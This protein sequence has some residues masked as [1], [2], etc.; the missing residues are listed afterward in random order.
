LLPATAAEE[1]IVYFTTLIN[2]TIA[3]TAIAES[4]LTL[5]ATRNI[6][7][8]DQAMKKHIYLPLS[9]LILSFFYLQINGQAYKNSIEE[10]P[11]GSLTEANIDSGKLT[12]LSKEISKG[13]N[14]IHS[15]LI[16]RNNKLV[17]ETYYRGKD[18]ILTTPVGEKDHGRDSLHDCRS[19]TKSV[20]SCCIGVAIGQHK[21]KSV[22]DRVFAYFPEYAKYDT[23]MKHDITIK[24]LLTM[25]AGIEWNENIPYSNPQN[26]EIQMLMSKDVIDFILNRPVSS[27]PGSTWNYSAGCTQL[28]AEIIR[29]AT[30]EKIDSFAKKYVFEPLGIRQFFWY[31]R[32]DGTPWAPS[33][34]RLRSIDMAKFG[35]LYLNKGKRNNSDVISFD[36]VKQSLAW[37][38][39]AR[40]LLQGYGYQFWCTKGIIAG[41]ETNIATAIGFGGQRI[42][43]I[44]ELNLEIV[45]TA[46]NYND[47]SDLPD[48][49]VSKYIFPAISK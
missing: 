14:N 27:R 11:I 36:W 28:L 31:E 10:L 16:L 46:G 25:S 15:L 21:I 32:E 4:S 13:E 29:K 34:L 9:V 23:G 48:Q 7:Y 1:Q 5:V 30:G 8:K 41:K 44:P 3:N 47:L 20:V 19:L 45:I 33:G 49:I 2:N 43:L 40:N 37:Q 42:Y 17:Y 26:S 38:I 39:N 12:Y 18:E 35:L 6:Y 24:D 22:N